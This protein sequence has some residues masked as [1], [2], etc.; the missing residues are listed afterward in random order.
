MIDYLNTHQWVYPA[1][2]FGLIWSM[3]KFGEWAKTNAPAL[4]VIPR[5]FFGILV[6]GV[7][8]GILL[9]GWP[10]NSIVP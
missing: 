7:I 6:A 8:I 3:A 9:S 5:V 10:V 1:V 4:E 2:F